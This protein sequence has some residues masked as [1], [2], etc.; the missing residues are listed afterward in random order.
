MRPY[1][2][3]ISQTISELWD[4]L[5]SMM[6]NAPTFVDDSGY[7]PGK[8]LE[9]TFFQLNESLKLLRPKF[10]EEN[11]AKMAELSARMRAHFE[12]DPEDKTDE[13]MKGRACI[14]AMEDIIKS[15][16]RKRG[17]DSLPRTE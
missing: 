1:K 14:T 8:N 11:Y 6:L 15:M 13:C 3:Y 4:L 5:G 10:G 9:T 17:P 7:F 16:R 12:A 2:P